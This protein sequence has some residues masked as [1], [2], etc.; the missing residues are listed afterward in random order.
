VMFRNMEKWMRFSDILKQGV[1]LLTYTLLACHL[2]ACWLHI[3]ACFNTYAQS[4]SFCWLNCPFNPSV[5]KH[6]YSHT[7]IE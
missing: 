1:K 4:Q 7:Y 5:G 2:G 3:M 6:T